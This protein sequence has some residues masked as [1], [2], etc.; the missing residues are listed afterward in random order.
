METNPDFIWSLQDDENE[1]QEN[2][3]SSKLEPKE[4]DTEQFEDVLVYD[5]DSTNEISDEPEVLVQSAHSHTYETDFVELQDSHELREINVEQSR[6]IFVYDI[7]PKNE[8]EFSNAVLAQSEQ[9][10][11]EEANFVELQNSQEDILENLYPSEEHT[12]HIVNQAIDEPE[13]HVIETITE[14]S[15]AAKRQYTKKQPEKVGKEK[16]KYAKYDWVTSPG[17]P[18]ESTLTPIG[19]TGNIEED[20]SITEIDIVDESPITPL[21]DLSEVKGT[22]RSIYT[23]PSQEFFIGKKTENERDFP[24]RSSGTLNWIVHSEEVVGRMGA[25]RRE[26]SRN[27]EV[28]EEAFLEEQN[29]PENILENI[30]IQTVSQNKLPSEE[31]IGV[32]DYQQDKV[33]GA[34]FRP[35][36]NDITGLSYQQFYEEDLQDLSKYEDEQ[37]DFYIAQAD[38]EEIFRDSSE[39]NQQ[40]PEFARE[41]QDAELGSNFEEQLDAEEKFLIRFDN[42]GIIQ[43]INYISR[44]TGRN[45]IFDN[46]DLDFNVTIISSEPTSVDDIMTALLQELRIHNL[47][48]MEVGNNLIIHRNPEAQSPAEIVT[49]ENAMR[50]RPDQDLVTRVFSLSNS[51]P[52]QMAATIRPLLSQLAI[53]EA[54]P[55]T[56]HLIITDLT[57]NVQRIAV[58]IKKLD[59]PAM[60]FEMGQYSVINANLT[61]LIELAQRIMQPI[62]GERPIVFVPHP[63]RNSIY[64][65]SSPY[66]VKQALAVLAKID[67]PRG[68][69]EV[70]SLGDFLDTL[71]GRDGTRTGATG[72]TTGQFGARQPGQPGRQRHHQR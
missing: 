46:L 20:S 42:V 45:F 33:P 44:I 18:Y 21:V 51:S 68:A 10:S 60:K 24:D 64:V 54:V 8:S 69:T 47:S 17:V 43:F 58:L 53:V 3:F 32:G 50:I 6:D 29:F 59:T 5:I 11:K 16:P 52:E 30:S 15:G 41:N 19:Y 34:A 13:D 56:G 37:E 14:V 38:D 65:I 39:F 28:T 40:V 9:Q 49:D 27:K 23:T 22:H 7:E 66:L 36:S 71:E 1:I 55:E 62:A 12:P 2:N 57:V 70:F 63:A 26:G 48:L 72:F 35:N 25:S 67:S 61:S 4:T 31:S